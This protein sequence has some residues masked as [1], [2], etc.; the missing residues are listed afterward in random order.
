MTG[1]IVHAS[2]I[3]QVCRQIRTA[4]KLAI[5]LLLTIHG[6]IHVLGFI[7]A[8]RP[9]AVPMLRRDLSLP[10]GV[11][12]LVVGDWLVL[13]AVLYQIDYAKWWV[14]AAIG[15][16][17]SQLLIVAS[18]SDAKW[19]TTANLVLLLPVLLQFAQQRFRERFSTAVAQAF[20][21]GSG[22]D[23]A[24]L[25]DTD[26]A[27]LPVVV[28]RYIR[29][30]GAIGQPHVRCFKVAMSG[31]LRRDSGAEW[32]PFEAVQYNFVEPA[33][34]Y[35]FLNATMSKL[36]V[37]GFHSY[38]NGAAFM[39]I[40]LFSMIPVQRQNGRE[41]DTAETVTFFNDMCCLAPGT[42]IDPR[43]RWYDSG[44]DYAHAKF[45][46]RGI[47]VSASLEFDASGRLI[48]FKSSDRFAT[49]GTEMRR[50]PWETPLTEY[51]A[52][53]DYNL[54]SGAQA[55]YHDPSGSFCY[56]RFGVD[57]VIYNPP[58]PKDY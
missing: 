6:G 56:G 15:V 29:Y 41:M 32:M 18:W 43:I 42:L 40:R 12:W 39:D 4:M 21:S 54:A 49:K 16:V 46:V 14:P 33:Q 58:S 10:V 45:T 24:L 57:S 44:P 13:T 31:D 38:D 37:A 20:L 48:C 22:R 34:R 9:D 3:S 23:T 27:R 50:Q 36:P 51:R 5:S 47:T 35:F 17:C 7:K 25:R 52:Y 1:V 8:I 55:I 26:M 11:M 2:G 19:G 30:S 28:Q 53:G